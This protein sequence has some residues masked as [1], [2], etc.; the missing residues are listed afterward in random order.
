MT[1]D[2]LLLDFL[3]RRD[4]LAFESI[5]QRYGPMVFRIC[6]DILG[7]REDAQ[8]AFQATFVVLIRQAGSIRE[9]GSLGRWLYEVAARISRRER[10]RVWKIRSQE[11]QALEME[12]PAPPDSDP[13][14]REL[15]PILH[16]E[17]QSLP[18]RLRDPIVLC[19][20]EGLT[21]EDAARSMQC[22]LGT[23]KSRLRKGRELL[24]A[25]LNR[26][27][28]SASALLF[29]MFSMTEEVSAEIPRSLLDSTVK[30]SFAGV[31]GSNLSW[32]VAAMVLAEEGRKFSFRFTTSLSLFIALLVM[33]TLLIATRTVLGRIPSKDVPTLPIIAPGTPMDHRAELVLPVREIGLPDHCR[34]R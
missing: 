22:P 4:E 24:R 3:S 14:D 8:D 28:L 18:S 30:A 32:K 17:I 9:R 29:L 7:D 6:L 2:Q 20:F 11:R 10:R 12:A 16:D 15:K 21:V 31:G 33:T 5:V 13:A 34:L 23:I 26:R 1:D 27:G 25:R 19:Y